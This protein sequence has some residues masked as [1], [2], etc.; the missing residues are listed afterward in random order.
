MLQVQFFWTPFKV[1][2]SV[3]SEVYKKLHHNLVYDH[4]ISNPVSLIPSK[5]KGGS[6]FG[7]KE[8]TKTLQVKKR[9]IKSGA[10]ACRSD[11]CTRGARVNGP[12]R[13]PP[14]PATRAPHPA[15]RVARYVYFLPEWRAPAR[16]LKCA[17]NHPYAETVQKF[18]ITIKEVSY[19]LFNFHYYNGHVLPV[20]VAIGRDRCDLACR[21]LLG[22]PD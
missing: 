5:S 22:P 9:L 16:K 4:D 8:K 17:L 2:S 12:W 11:M 6:E 19:L 21:V 20:D 10:G 7:Q 13:A 14:Q 15:P 18:V 3:T 1:F